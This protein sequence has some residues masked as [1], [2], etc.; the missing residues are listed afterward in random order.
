MTDP[1]QHSSAGH[2]PERCRAGIDDLIDRAEHEAAAG[3][4]DAAIG[5]LVRELAT[6][7]TRDGANALSA[8]ELRRAHADLVARSGDL[9]SAAY[10]LDELVRDALREHG[11]EA[12]I[13]RAC[14][15][16][17]ARVL[18]DAGDTVRAAELR[19]L[20]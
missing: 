10:S 4:V 1:A 16:T 9:E 6:V 12:D 13:V 2:R 19:A 5:L 18:E 8:L 3:N 7:L 20:L 17:Y 11:E 14:R 15:V